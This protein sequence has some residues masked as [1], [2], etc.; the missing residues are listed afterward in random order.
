MPDSSYYPIN[1]IGYEWEYSST[2]QT[3]DPHNEKI[4]DTIRVND[5]LY[6]KLV[7]NNS[8]E[9]YFIRE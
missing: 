4:T 2:R 7:I 8:D 5:N 9:G 3:T 1:Q 6:Y